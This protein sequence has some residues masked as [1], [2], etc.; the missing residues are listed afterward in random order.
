MVETELLAH[1][2]VA[3]GVFE[4]NIRRRGE[5][6]ASIRCGNVQHRVQLVAQSLVIG[7]QRKWISV[8]RGR[9]RIHQFQ[10][11]A[12][13]VLEFLQH[14][15]LHLAAAIGEADF[16]QIVLNHRLRFCAGLLCSLNRDRRRSSCRCS[17]LGRRIDW[18]VL[19]L[20]LSRRFGF[21]SLRSVLFQKRLRNK[22]DQECDREDEE[23]PLLHSWFLLRVLEVCQSLTVEFPSG[24]CQCIAF[25]KPSSAFPAPAKG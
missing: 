13:V 24:S 20:T 6:I 4:R 1:C 7:P 10:R 21:R 14:P 3:V 17:G 8:F 18:L 22:N 15:R 11:L 12:F 23:K 9:C 25:A 16:V 2:D 5:G 19:R